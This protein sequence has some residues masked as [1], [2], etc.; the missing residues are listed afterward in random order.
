VLFLIQSITSATW[1]AETWPL[2]QPLLRRAMEMRRQIAREWLVELGEGL[3]IAAASLST[4]WIF[5][6]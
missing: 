4:F 1:S 5:V 6:P 3:V 2:V